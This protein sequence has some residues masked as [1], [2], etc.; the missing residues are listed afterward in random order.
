MAAL[1]LTHVTIVG[2]TVFLH[3]HQAHRA[4]DLHPVVGH[5]FRFWLWLTTGMVTREWVAIHRKHHAKC[6]TPA[7]PHSPQ[8]LGL[9][10]VLWQGAELYRGAAG[11]P[12]ILERYGQGAPDD[13]L[14]R[15]LYSRYS[16]AGIGLMAALDLVLFGPVGLTIWAVQ[17]V[18]IPFWAAG[19]I[20][21]VGHYGGYRNFDSPD[22]STNL[23]PWGV[24][25]GGEELHNNHHAFPSSA[26]FSNRPWEFDIG[27]FY[28]RLL[29]R[30][31]L[32]RVRKL[33]PHPVLGEARGRLDLEA[34]KALTVNRIHL[35]ADYRRR[36]LRPVMRAELDNVGGTLRDLLKRARHPLLNDLSAGGGDGAASVA[37]VLAVSP[38]LRAVHEQ[39]RRLVAIWNERAATHEWR[40]QALQQWC[41][42][43]E[44]SGIEALRAFTAVMR[45]Y[46][47]ADAR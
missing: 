35:F 32:A 46:R 36:V 38:V 40:L 42:E 29:E 41:A 31:G 33:A 17:M 15:H 14:E 2:V 43:A 19:V 1:L 39:R 6:E 9:R 12:E 30:A 44:A 23:L 28:I 47:L 34:V 10:K 24:L 3:R 11:E 26:R 37:E 7:D 45:S 18:W 25:I 22:A 13:W 8:V 16:L 20:N 4:L 21:G 27:W 5:F